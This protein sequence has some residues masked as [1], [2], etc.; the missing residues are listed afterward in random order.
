[1]RSFPQT[2]TV[3]QKRPDPL[4]TDDLARS[5]RTGHP[6]AEDRTLMARPPYPGR[7]HYFIGNKTRASLIERFVTHPQQAPYLRE[8]GRN[9]HIGMGVLHRELLELQR[10]GLVRRSTRGRTL[11]Y[12][13]D[14]YH[15]IARALCELVT[16]SELCDG[17]KVCDARSRSHPC[18]AFM[19]HIS[20]FIVDRRLNTAGSTSMT[21]VDWPTTQA[22][23]SDSEHLALVARAL[24]HPARIRILQLLAEQS[25]CKGAEVFSELPLAQSTISEHL[26]VLKEAGLVS[27]HPVGTA[28]TY[29]LVSERI[30]AF[31]HALDFAVDAPVSES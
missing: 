15:P 23:G 25:E 31:T 9:L 29:C 20:S 26:R 11:C 14:P 17:C 3:P 1:V 24:S 13:L 8:L 12:E 6:R 22:A 16:V 2:P 30:A 7:F 18:K 19:H 28:M 4:V 5:D 21:Q 27:A 10:M